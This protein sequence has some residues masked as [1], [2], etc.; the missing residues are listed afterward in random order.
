M[1]VGHHL[2]EERLDVAFFTGRRADL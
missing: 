2:R 1:Q